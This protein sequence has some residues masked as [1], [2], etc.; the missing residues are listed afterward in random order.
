MAMGNHSLHS[1][2]SGGRRSFY[3]FDFDENILSLGTPSFLYH[4]GTGEEVEVTSQE[5]LE[6]REDIGHRGP[7]REF[8]IRFDL[9]GSFRF[10]HDQ[11]HPLQEDRSPQRFLNDLSEALV[12]PQLRWQGP[13]WKTFL[14][15]VQNQRPVS[16]ITARGHHPETLKEGFSFLVKQGHLPC[17]PNYLSLFPVS[18]PK[19]EEEL[20]AGE[21]FLDIPELKRRAFRASVEK[22]L[23]VFGPNED[24]RFGMSDDDPRNLA[25]ISAEMV[26][27][28]Q[29]YP[30]IGFYVIDT[31]NG[32][33]HMREVF[34]P[35]RS[36]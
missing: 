17:E 30:H 33:E 11:L 24:H 27:M 23:Q 15:A 22:A 1:Q 25:A 3:F 36:P 29:Q 20:R 13:S 8:E 4:K 12:C 6:H 26:S 2:N 35:R 18:H 31:E 14:R 5:L 28:K 21:P 19:V 9:M 7:W 32:K 34:A 10:F 16:L